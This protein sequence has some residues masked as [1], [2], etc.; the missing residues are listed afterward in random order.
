MKEGPD[1]RQERHTWWLRRTKTTKCGFV[2]E[3]RLSGVFRARPVRGRQ[4]PCWLAGVDERRSSQGRV[5]NILGKSSSSSR[6]SYRSPESRCS[7]ELEKRS[8]VGLRTG[9]EKK[10]SSIRESC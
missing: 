2:V 1:S 10:S 3:G 6:C 8:S 4:R 9:E 7:G 5:D